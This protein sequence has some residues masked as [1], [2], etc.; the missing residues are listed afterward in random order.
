MSAPTKGLPMTAKWDPE[1]IARESAELERLDRQPLFTRIRGYMQLTGPAWMQ[2]AM[3][4]GAGSATASV[5]A[6]AFFGYQLLWVQPIAMFLGIMMMA[7]LGNIV[8]SSGERPFGAFKRELH[9]LLAYFWAIGA[10][11]AS[12][13]W[14]LPQYGLAGAVAWD[15]AIVAG[16][17]EDR[18]WVWYLVRFG[19]GGA[20]LGINIFTTWNYG[21][22]S[23]GIKFYEGFLRWTIRLVIIAFAIVVLSTGVD[24]N[25]LWRGFFTFQVPDSPA[26]ITVI[27]GAIGA[28]VGINMT[29]LYPYSILARGWGKNHKGLSR[30]DLF[31]SMF[32]PYTILTT[33]IIVAMA[34]TKFDPN[35]PVTA[36]LMGAF[37][38]VDAAGA[39][40]G[41]VGPSLGR[42]IFDLGF[43]G[44]ALGAISTHMVVCG[45]TMCEML[46]LEYTV[47]RYRMFT[48]VPAICVVGVVTPGPLW[49][50]IVASA[51][52]LTMMP[53][54]YIAFFILNNKRSYL[55]PAVGHGW[56]RAVFNTLLLCAIAATTVATIVQ[57]KTRVVDKLI[58]PAP[59]AS[60]PAEAT[61]T[62][63]K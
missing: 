29:F 35:V 22:G 18:D 24:W 43:L 7:A 1:R 26:S 36:Q 44:M 59:A 61:P 38:P 9:P 55:G 15:L 48:L 5:I 37:K 41:V 13:V 21:S 3:T 8:L 17:P 52:C 20:I 62:N 27:L 10:I 28:A 25:A 56:K 58:P 32:L 50:P 19:A 49:M 60:I 14:H 51:I 53:I 45:F 57:V 40:S 12:V 63:S 46:G 30:W 33:L 47:K 2:S 4:L 6:G 23:R 54:I 31:S 39:L 16:A 11:V 42:I 34:N